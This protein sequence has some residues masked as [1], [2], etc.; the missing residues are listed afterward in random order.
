ML[1]F[2][3]LASIVAAIGI[4]YD[5]VAVV[6]GSMVI[7]PLLTP[8]IALSLA[9]TIADVKLAKQAVITSFFGYLT[10]FIIGIIFGILF[11]VD[12]NAPQ[13]LSRIDLN[14]IYVLLAFVAGIAG[15]LSFIKGIARPLVGVMVA[16]ALLPPIVTSGLLFGSQQWIGGM[17]A[18]LLSSVNVV[19]INLAGVVTFLSQGISPKKW[20]EKEKAKKM[21]IASLILWIVLL[22]VLVMLM[23]FFEYLK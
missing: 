18:F 7:A 4:L 9:T 12:V 22:L 23:I 8:S 20:W 17:G 19:G 10:A 5:N 1:V 3:V 6:I 2:I 21:T 15:S 13:I 16:V 11:S 14:L